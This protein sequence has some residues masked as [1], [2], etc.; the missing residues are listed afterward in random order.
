MDT[1]LNGHMLNLLWKKKPKLSCYC[2]VF[3]FVQHLQTYDNRT[4]RFA[5]KRKKEK[6]RRIQTKI[7]IQIELNPKIEQT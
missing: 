7:K 4:I 2:F 6:K 1:L 5:K 3:H